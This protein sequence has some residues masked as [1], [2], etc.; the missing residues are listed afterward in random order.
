MPDQLLDRF[1]EDLASSEAPSDEDGTIIRFSDRNAMIVTGEESSSLVQDAVT[2]AGP[3]LAKLKKF[4]M[5][6]S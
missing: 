2:A 3:M 5:G 1:L 6:G 4:S